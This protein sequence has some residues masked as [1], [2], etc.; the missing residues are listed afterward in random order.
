MSSRHSAVTEATVPLPVAAVPHRRSAGEATGFRPD[1]EGLRAIAI[2]LVLIF[3]AGLPYVTGGYIGVDI[4]FVI[5]GFL[6]T[7]QLVGELDGTGRIS[8]A[9]FYARRA[10]RILP[11]AAVVLLATAVLS[12]LYLPRVQWADAG[13]DI[14]A[15]ALYVVNWRLADRSV[16]YLAEG[17]GTSPVQHFWSL[18]VEEQFYLVWPLLMI[19]AALVARL[20]R[21]RSH[22]SAAAT[23]RRGPQR[24]VLLLAIAAV[25]VPSFLWSMRETD[26]SAAQ[27]FFVTTTRMWELAVGAAVALATPMLARLPRAVAVGIG[28]IGVV[29]VVAS[30][31]VFT[32]ASAWPGHLAAVPTL[33]A[34]AVIAGG[35][36]GSRGGPAVVLGTR[37]MRWVGRL[38]YS[39]YLWHWPL[40]VIAAQIRGHMG[41]LAGT[42]VVIGSF[43]PAWLSYKLVENP[44]RRSPAVN[45]SPRLALSLGVNFTLVGVV[46][47]LLVMFVAAQAARP[48]A[49][50]GVALGAQALPS[51]GPSA[52]PAIP[53][54]ADF[55]TPDPLNANDD[56]PD[57]YGRGCQQSQTDDA[58]LSCTDGDPQ[59]ST[60]VV[61]AGDSKIV[62]YAP[63]LEALA[64]QNH[65][66]LVTY[67]KSSCS[68]TSAVIALDG[69]PYDSCTRWNQ[70]LLDR[71]TAE[72][73]DYVI[74][75][76]AANSALPQPG[77]LADPVAAMVDGLRRSWSALSAVGTKVI[78]FGD[79]PHPGFEVYACVDQH[80]DDLS[81]CTYDSS[82]RATSGGYEAQSQAIVGE[83]GVA[84]VDLWDAIC[85]TPRCPPVIGNVLVYRQGSHLTA[86]YVKTLTPRIAAALTD[87]GLPAQPPQ[88]SP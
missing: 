49:P 54:R 70:A 36:A 80:R 85:P 8:L 79:N 52:T 25:G 77:E 14:L 69:K 10:K 83:P 48:T 26:Y 27:A 64:T 33:G 78:V 42:L 81:Q 60:T 67:T 30:G 61:I 13:G 37:P 32:T 65:W 63:A 24:W 19:I 11:A 55:I 46:S 74:T 87:A 12:R 41:P 62:Q 58:L 47:G 18:A 3:H 44:I 76:G 16:D 45:R 9:G 35:F 1:V 6:I 39:L 22:E 88:L 7:T 71:L 21:P 5:S 38:S 82:R 57:L 75:S 66:R 15:S 72:R 73:P 59:S 53:D 84:M 2:S 40:L 17:S 50:P 56:V 34:A 31:F 86:T 4:F 29:A 68:F 28:W 20:L 43:V 23:A 51:A